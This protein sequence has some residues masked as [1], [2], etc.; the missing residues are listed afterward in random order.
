MTAKLKM[1][2]I[3][4]PVTNVC[5]S[6][7]ERQKKLCQRFAQHRGY[8][9]NG[10]VDKATGE[11]F[12][13]AGPSLADMRVTVIEQVQSDDPMMR[14]TRESH[15]IDKLNSKHKGMNRKQ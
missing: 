9:R 10:K 12:N 13:L 5:S 7:W 3:V 14:K 1:W 15:F 6:I 2:Y 11:H 4:F 8:I